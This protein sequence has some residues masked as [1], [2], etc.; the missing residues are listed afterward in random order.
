[1]TKKTA[2]RLIRATTLRQ[3]QILLA[4]VRQ[5]SYTGAAK[6]LHLTQPTVSMQIRKL[7]DH[8]GQ[9]LFEPGGR[10]LTLTP[11]GSRVVDAAQEIIHRL[12]RLSGELNTLSG[13]IKGELRIGVVTTAKYFM[14]HM[15]GAFIQRHTEVTPRLTET[16]RANVLQRLKE[17][18][19]DLSIMGKVPEG[20]EVKAYP[21]LD[22]DLVVVAPANHPLARRRAIPLARLREER[23]LVREQGS[24]T[25]LAMDR[26]FEQEGLRLLPYMEL[27]S[28]E[29]IKQA[30][31]AGLGISVMSQHN[32]RLELKSGEMCVLDVKGFPL[33]RHWYAVHPA[34]Q[35][36]GVVTRTFLDFLL[37]EGSDLWN[38]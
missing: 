8:I 36:P 38:E 13:E 6:A 9:P 19:D 31:M 27:G 33:R 2:E 3:L 21:F 18:R 17:N 22:N 15:L 34:N 30:M 11:A 24:G 14:P 16:N 26:L 25:R 32:L 23:I 10:K 12:E 1:M 29:T 28:I 4:V 37:N 20:L 35:H 5:G 7:A